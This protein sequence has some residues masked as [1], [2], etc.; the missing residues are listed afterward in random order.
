MSKE[1]K[2]AFKKWLRCY[3]TLDSAMKLRVAI[4]AI[5]RPWLDFLEESA[6]KVQ[7]AGA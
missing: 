5:N 3:R 1:E 7:K 4:D 2:E 6:T